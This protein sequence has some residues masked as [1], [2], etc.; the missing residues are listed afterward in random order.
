[1]ALTKN[2]QLVSITLTPVAPFPNSCSVKVKVTLLPKIGVGLFTA[3]LIC[4]S[5]LVSPSIKFKKTPESNKASPASA[6][7]P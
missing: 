5:A 6:I 3:L 7:T 2:N 1:V 4:K